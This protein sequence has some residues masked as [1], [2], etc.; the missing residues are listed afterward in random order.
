M[1]APALLL[2]IPFLTGAAAAFVRPPPPVPEILLAGA[3]LFGLIAAAGSYALDN[4]SDS[5]ALIDSSQAASLG[6]HRALLYHEQRGT[7]ET[8][9]PYA[10]PDASW[11]EQAGANLRRLGK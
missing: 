11:I 5:A 1:Y 2:A 9:R 8:F 6:L 3:A 10:M 7:L 4:R